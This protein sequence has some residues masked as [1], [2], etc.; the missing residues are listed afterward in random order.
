MSPGWGT[1]MCCCDIQA[2]DSPGDMP[3]FFGDNEELQGCV[4][5]GA[6]QWGARVMP[7]WAI[8][9]QGLRVVSTWLLG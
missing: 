8:G 3:L 6:G 9:Q 2:W 7:P 1:A 4:P 5:W